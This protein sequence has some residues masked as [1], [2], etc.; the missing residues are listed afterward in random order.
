MF[1]MKFLTSKGDQDPEIERTINK[2]ITFICEKISF[3]NT[4]V[5]SDKNSVEFVAGREDSGDDQQIVVELLIR[6]NIIINTSDF[7]DRDQLD[8]HIKKIKHFCEQA[9]S[10]EELK[11]LPINMR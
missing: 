11:Y 2:L 7:K 10:I 4:K 6:K 3:E 5:L 9:K 1:S 8:R